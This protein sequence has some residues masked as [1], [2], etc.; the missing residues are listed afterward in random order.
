MLPIFVYVCR[1]KYVEVRIPQINESTLDTCNLRISD[2]SASAL[3][4]LRIYVLF[5]FLTR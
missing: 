4:H 5:Y 1:Y 2:F 3:G